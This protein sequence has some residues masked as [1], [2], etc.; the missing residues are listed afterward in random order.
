FEWVPALIPP[1]PAPAPATTAPAPP[2]TSAPARGLPAGF[3]SRPAGH[4]SGLPLPPA[5]PSTRVF[6]GANV[7][8]AGGRFTHPNLLGSGFS[9]PSIGAHVG[10][11][12]TRSIAVGLDFSAYRSS[13]EYV[14]DGK[15]GYTAD[16]NGR[17]A[18][19]VRVAA[20]CSTC[21]EGL[22]G[23]GYEQ[24]GPLNVLTLGPRLQFAPDPA[25]GLYGAVTGGVTF[26]EATIA[27]RTGAAFGARGGYRL[28]VSEQVGVALELGGTAHRFSGS[29]SAFGFG[30]LQLQMRL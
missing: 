29:T 10:V 3:A 23:G 8:W 18:N 13:L 6:M 20:R 28:A 2:P 1:A 15:Y 25:R 14:G 7:G 11:A 26:L 17:Y 4:D 21:P 5:G 16:D 30:G 12:L 24:S 22:P 27:N 19:G 9:G